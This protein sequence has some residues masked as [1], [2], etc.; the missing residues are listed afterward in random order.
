MRRLACLVLRHLVFSVPTLTGLLCLARCD[1]D[2]S[3]GISSS[4]GIWDS[5]ILLS[6]PFGVSRTL[7][8]M[9]AMAV[10]LDHCVVLA[11]DNLLN[12]VALTLNGRGVR[13]CSFPLILIWLKCLMFRLVVCL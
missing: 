9:S 3:E 7:E 5:G 13:R 6:L 10:C 8:N 4:S 2:S 11:L 1:T 12:A